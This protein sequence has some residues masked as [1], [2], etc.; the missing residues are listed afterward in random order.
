MSVD[1]RIVLNY[2]NERIA[3]IVLNA[4]ELDNGKH[5]VSRV[6]GNDLILEASALSENSMLHTLEDL[7]SCVKVAS[8]MAQRSK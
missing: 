5:A 8:E 3:R 2:P 1:C 4:I 6:E 7:L